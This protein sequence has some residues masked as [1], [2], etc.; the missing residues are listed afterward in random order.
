MQTLNVDKIGR[1][2]YR[3]NLD[4]VQT[5]RYNTKFYDPNKRKMELI[6]FEQTTCMKV[7]WYSVFSFLLFFFRTNGKNGHLDENDFRHGYGN[8]FES[9]I[10]KVT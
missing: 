6:G 10:L 3:K 9:A 5:R 4:Y 2:N 8:Y 7:P 1:Q